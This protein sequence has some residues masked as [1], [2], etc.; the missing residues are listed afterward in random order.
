MVTNLNF[1]FLFLLSVCRGPGTRQPALQDSRKARELEA[2][3]TLDGL[4]VGG[5]ELQGEVEH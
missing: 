4:A 5:G 1:R 3:S 2:V